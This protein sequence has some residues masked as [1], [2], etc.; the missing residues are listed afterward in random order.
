[1]KKWIV[2]SI[3]IPVVGFILLNIIFSSNGKQVR[4]RKG[5]KASSASIYRVIADQQT[6]DKLFPGE[7]TITKKLLN[8]VHINTSVN[9]KT[10]P[11][12]IM[13]I[14]E[15]NDSTAVLWESTVPAFSGIFSTISEVA[16]GHN[17]INKIT[18]TID[19]LKNFS[20]HSINI[21]GINIIQ[22][23]TKDTSLITTKFK[24]HTYPLNEEIYAQIAKLK[25]FAA[26]HNASPSGYPMLN[27]STVDS[28]VYHCMVALPIDRVIQTGYSA[29]IR[30]VYMVPGRFLTAEIKG[31]PH[32]IQHAH[33]MMQQYFQDYKRTAM[34]I[35]FEYLVTDRL[36]E[37][38][39]SQWITRI[40]APVY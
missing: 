16:T 14:P 18:H 11:G 23:S 27:V 12:S 25:S 15:T 2:I 17:L 28:S 31:G 8:S 19:S 1:M 21:Y 40:Y 9:N 37:K 20:I 5:I 29:P 36:N 30:Y 26:S 24:T 35:P 33:K 22:T 6:W 4:V 38:D 7:F 32:T 34:A 39:T 13:L 3:A 10:A